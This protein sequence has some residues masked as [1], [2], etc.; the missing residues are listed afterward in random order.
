METHDKI[1]VLCRK[2]LL[3]CR[4]LANF[5]YPESDK[6]EQLTRVPVTAKK[7]KPLSCQKKHNIALR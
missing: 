4:E 7:K 6:I 5:A 2:L 3:T 1:R